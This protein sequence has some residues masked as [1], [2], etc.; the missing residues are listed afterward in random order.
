MHALLYSLSRCFVVIHLF[1]FTSHL[2]PFRSPRVLWPAK[3]QYRA[4]LQLP[5]T[6]KASL[7]CGSGL[8]FLCLSLL[9]LRCLIACFVFVKQQ[10]D[11]QACNDTTKRGE[12][13]LLFMLLL[14]ACWHRQ[15][16]RKKTQSNKIKHNMYHMC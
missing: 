9:L 4:T 14:F 16:Q 2:S 15:K 3:R 10:R 7:A 1:C 13:N 11:R 12:Y 8:L 6:R 5:R